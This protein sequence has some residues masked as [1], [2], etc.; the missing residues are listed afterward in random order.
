MIAFKENQSGPVKIDK[1]GFLSLI[2]DKN[3]DYKEYQ[4]QREKIM[5]KNEQLNKNL[6]EYFVKMNNAIK[7]AEKFDMTSLRRPNVFYI[8]SKE[9][10]DNLIMSSND[11]ML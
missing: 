10:D 5:K 7:S 2:S 1:E 8:E 9:E 4:Y 6:Q 3:K 11:N